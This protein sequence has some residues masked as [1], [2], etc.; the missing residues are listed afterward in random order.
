MFVKRTIAV[1]CMLCLCAAVGGQ[2]NQLDANANAKKAGVAR[3]NGRT[4]PGSKSMA[5][6][7]RNGKAGKVKPQSFSWGAGKTTTRRPGAGMGLPTGQVKAPA[8][9]KSQESKSKGRSIKKHQP[10]K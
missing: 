2:T 3:S 8:M 10:V 7:R 9:R 6:K 5:M 4:S 1:I